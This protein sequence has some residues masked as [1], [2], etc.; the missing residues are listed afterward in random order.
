[1]PA[2]KKIKPK[3]VLKTKKPTQGNIRLAK[4][5]KVDRSKP[6]KSNKLYQSASRDIASAVK[7]LQTFTNPTY[8]DTELEYFEDAWANSV[9]GT[10]MDK[11]MEFVMG[12]GVKPTFELKEDKGLTPEQKDKA[13]HTKE[14]DEVLDELIQMDQKLG[15][16]QKLFDAA[17]M[18]KVFGR[19]VLTWE[20]DGT[21]I[22]RPGALKVIHPRDTGRVF[23]NQETWELDQ[24]TTFNPS[25][26]I[27][28]P[29]MI[30]LVNRPDSPIRKT[31][32][33]GFS[34][35][36]RIIGAARAWRRIVEF[37]MPEITTAMWA[38]YG[39]FLVKK[40]GR[41]SSD[42]DA[43]LNALL[44]S[45]KPGAFNAVAVEATD[46]IQ[47]MTADLDPKVAELVSLADFYERVMIGNFQVPSALLGREEDQ[48]R[49]TLIGKIRFFI[50]G[51]VE[52][53][54]EW[55]GDMIGPQWYERNLK[56]LGHEKILDEIRIK[57]EFEPIFVENW[58]DMIEGVIKLKGLFPGL[59]DEKLLEML[60]LEE[61]END[62][63]NS[64][65]A[66]DE[67]K[68]E[69]VADAKKKHLKKDALMIKF[70]RYMKILEDNR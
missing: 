1:V 66:I 58:E 9:A 50:E 2:K 35:L 65:K 56:A 53:D 14:L 45:L 54:R 3:L 34:E 24:V 29:E 15:F 41:N 69:L 40:M 25:A 48:N 23:L 21:G 57:P 43:D 31:Q 8:T 70:E 60:K 7:N 42:T 63:D 52:S 67:Q 36:Q 30:Y 68:Q 11:K 38:S 20:Q 33:F 59:P 19:C 46:Y 16:N 22:E 12:R 51:P 37:D 4:M 49:A 64:A 17:I 62:I 32:L 13:L 28:P 61:F 27:S 39:M 5:V 47:F 6:D 44:N 55:L 10:A 18:A 26:S